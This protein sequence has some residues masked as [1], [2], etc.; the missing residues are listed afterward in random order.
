[1]QDFN[2]DY[3]RKNK[4]GDDVGIS[5]RRS[6]PVLGNPEVKLDYKDPQMLRNFVTE[7]GKLI[8]RRVS[9]TSAKGQRAVALAVRRAR[10]IALIP[11]AVTGK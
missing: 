1:M 4:G 2:D 9:G 8:P 3:G 5:R 10:M 6:C 11:F 7:R